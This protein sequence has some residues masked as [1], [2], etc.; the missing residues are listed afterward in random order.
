VAEPVAEVEGRIAGWGG[1]LSVAAVNGPRATVVSGEPGALD[2]LLAAC[3]VDG[4]RARRIPVDYASHS[5]QVDGLRERILTD[6]ASLTPRSGSVPF[7]STVTGAE[8][9]TAGLDGAYWFENL[10]G[11]VRFAPVVES[12]VAQGFGTFV[13]ASAHPVLTMAIEDATAIGSLRRGEGGMERFVASL[14]EAWV[15]GVPVAWDRVFAGGRHVDVPTYPFQHRRYWL[16]AGTGTVSAAR[17][18]LGEAEHPLLA[19]GVEL[20]DSDGFLLT[21]ALSPRS[22]P[23]LADHAVNGVVLLPGT[24]M[25][26]MAVHAGDQVGCGHVDELVLE[27]PLALAVSGDTYLQLVV[28]AADETG[29]R[30]LS[31]H[32]RTGA[33]GEWT[34]HATGVISPNVPAPSGELTTWPPEGAVA[35]DLTDF[36]AGAAEAGF[37]Y[38][39]AFRGLRAAWRRGGAADGEIFAEVE[40]PEAAEGRGSG[41]FALHP[42]LFDAG[43]QALRVGGVL[44]GEG[45]LPFS[46]R[47]VTLH[48]AGAATVLR[49]RLSGRGADEVAIDVADDRG[50]PVLTVDSLV[51][52]P[53]SAGEAPVVGHAAGIAR[54]FLFRVIWSPLPPTTPQPAQ[55]DPAAGGAPEPVL[56]RL[57]VDADAGERGDLPR[58]AHAAVADALERARGWLADDANEGRRLVLV[59]R[60]AV[61]VQ[62]GEDV[63]DL[64]GAAAWGLLRSAQAEHPGRFTLLDTD[65]DPASDG[66][67][68]AAVAGGEPQLALRSGTAYVPRLDRHTPPLAAPDSPEAPEGPEAPG[69]WRLRLGDGSAGGGTVQNVVLAACPEVTEPLRPGQ[70]RVSVR[71]AGVNFRDVVLALG[72]VTGRDGG[73]GRDELGGEGAGVVLDVA[74]DVADLRPGDRVMG[75]LPGSFG[76]LAVADHRMLV[77]IP[78][79][80][81]FVQ[82]ATVPIAFL[83][84]AYGLRDLGGLRDGETVLVHAAAGGVGMAAVQLARHW[85]AEV[86]G[87]ASPGKWRTLRAHGLDPDHIASSRALGFEDAFRAATG[88]RGVDIVLNSLA[89]T[90][91]DAGQRLLAPGGRFIEMGKT[92]IRG[93]ALRD[94]VTYRAFDLVEARPDRVRDLLHELLELA[95]AG[96]LTPLPATTWDVRRAPEALRYLQQARHVGKIVL[97]LPAPGATPGRPL[98]PAGTVLITGGTGTLGSEV[99]RHLV[100][101]HGV[102]RLLLVSRRGVDAPGAA[103]LVAELAE[104]G[105]TAT[106]AA[107]DAADREELARLLA[108]I[109]AEHPLTAVIHAAGV[110]DDG[111]VGTL[112]PERLARVLRPKADAA[113]HLH[114]LTRDLDLAAFVLFSS[115]AGLLGGLGQGNY[116]AANAFLDG[117]ALHRRS[118]GLPA[119]SLAW[120]L[121]AERSGMTGGLGPEA[122]ARMGQAGIEEL[123]TEEGLAL[124][125][126]GLTAAET[127]LAP[128]RLRTAALR[129]RAAVGETPPLLR[130]LVRAAARRRLPGTGGD[131]GAGG[132]ATASA[133]E[134]L[135][136]VRT[137]ASAVLGHDTTEAVDAERAFRELGFD[138]LTAVELR[139]RLNAATGLRLPSTAVFDHPT[140]GALAAHLRSR[141]AP[142]TAERAVSAEPLTPKPAVAGGGEDPVVVVGMACRYPGGVDSP[143]ALWRLVAEGVDAVGAFP[144]DRGWDVGSL[145][146]PDPERSGTSYVREGGFLYGAAE[147]DAGFFGIS[148]REA[149][150]MDPQQRLL[151]ETSWEVFERAGIDPASVRSSATGVFTGLLHGGYGNGSAAARELEGYL[152]NG[153]AG[154]V[155]SGRVAYTFGLEGPAV[156]VD[157]ACSSSLVALHLAVQ[158]LRSG[159]CAMALAGGATV[160]A[161]PGAFVEFSRQR[162]LAPDGRCKPFAEGADGTGWAE[163]VGMLLLERLSDARRNGHRVLA[164]VRGSAVN[165]D[166]ASNG[167]TAPS[168]LAQQRVIRAALV[169]AGLSANE[170][171]AVEAHG[172]GTALGDP[173]EAQALLATYGQGREGERPLWLGSLKSNIGHAQAAAGVGG[174][175]KMVQAMHH[176]VLPR[177]L[178]VDRPSSHVDWDAGAVRLLTE[179]VEW[180]DTGRPRRA[181][182]SSFGVSGTNAHAILELPFDTGRENGA[183]DD[184][185]APGTRAFPVPVLLSADSAEALSAQ[186]LRLRDHLAAHPDALPADVGRSLALGRAALAHRAALTVSDGTDRDALLTDLD[187]LASGARAPRV[188]RGTPVDGTLAFLF[189][190]QGSQRPGM[191]TELAAAHPAFA[192][193]FDAVCAEFDRH[194]D[195]PLRQVIEAEPELLDRTE[196]AQPA[197][198]GV[199]VALFRLLESWQ[200]R[201]DHLLGHSAGAL[202]AAH[203]ADVLSLPDACLL[204]AARGRLMQAQRADGAMLAVQAT[205][206]EAAPFLASHEGRLALAAVNGPASVVLAG[207]ADAVDEAT[208]HWAAVGRRTKRLRTSHAFHSPHMDGML[209]AFATVAERVT[210]RPARIPVVSEVT[211][212]VIDDDELAGPAYWV[213]HARQPVRFADGIAYLHERGAR[214]FLELG[215]DAVLS[216]MGEECLPD[217]RDTAFLPT[218][219]GG[220]EE[221]VA[222][223]AAFGRLHVRGHAAHRAAYPAPAGART[224]PLPTYA[225]QRRRYWLAPGAPGGA[226]AAA[227][228]HPLLPD[229]VTLADGDGLLL[230]GR[231]SAADQPWLGDHTILGTVLV[232]GTALVEMAWHAGAH[233]GCGR[234]EELT[235]E[236]PLVLPPGGARAQVQVRVGAADGAGRRP[237]TLHSRPAADAEAPWTRHADGVLAPAGDT[238]AGDAPAPEPDATAWPPPGASAIDTADFYERFAAHGFDLGPAFQGLRAAWRDGDDLL[239]EVSLPE[240]E[241]GAAARYGIHPALLDAALHA[242]GLDA[243]DES[244]G[245][246][247]FAWHDVTRHA[248]GAPDLRVRLRPTGDDGVSVTLTDTVG[249]PV[250]RIGRLVT[251]RVTED[252]LARRQD[253][254]HRVEWRALP[255]ATADVGN[256]TD[257]TDATDVGDAV[258]RWAGIDPAGAEGLAGLD[259]LALH[260]DP[261]HLAKDLA[262]GGPL[263]EAVLVPLDPDPGL[264]PPEAAHDIARRAGDLVRAWLAGEFAP[265]RLV[266]VTRGAVRLGDAPVRPAAA[267]AWGL[268]ASVQAEHPGRFVLLDAEAGQPLAPGPLALALASDEPRLALRAGTAHVPRLVRAGRATPEEPPAPWDPEGTVLV[269]GATGALG[270]ALAR[271]LAERGARRL[272]LVSRSGADAP[273]AAELSA[274]LAALGATAE[275]RSCDVADRDGLAALLDGVRDDHPLTAVVHLAGVLDDGLVESLTPERLE[276]VLR[277]KADA[278]WHLHE[279]TKGLDLAAFVLFSSASGVIG[280]AGQANYAAANAFLDALAHHRHA[281]GLPAQSLAWGAWEV[282]MAGELARAD[283]DRLARSGAVPL[284]TGEGMALFDAACRTPEP[285]L[286]PLRLDP[287]AL[288]AAGAVP[289]LLRDL[290]PTRARRGA[291]TAGTGTAAAEAA[292]LRRRLT[293]LG[294]AKTEEALLDLIRAKAALAL[295]HAGADAIEPGRG[296]TQAGFDSLATVELRNRLNEVTG[297][298]LASTALFDHPTPV[299]LA[300][301]MGE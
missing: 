219:R 272:L 31:L 221:P 114:E 233:A 152:G 298:R 265:A 218:L 211:G 101:A 166:G 23:W 80:W 154:S 263:P 239:A 104:S 3:E 69:A 97:T 262:D 148:P 238:P 6:L 230:S 279:L 150:A 112:T 223:A 5:A 186:A 185:R 258:R 16:D 173:I 14:A 21:G 291:A 145:Y 158:S 234:V 282:G 130:G 41:D 36:Y 85:G 1:R 278:A 162:G 87:T 267:A 206:D 199:Q 96:V 160:M 195:R 111:V 172:T 144:V 151:L 212:A 165:Q 183:A 245:R 105:A 102:R 83:T 63:A 57:G 10:R 43:L 34:R 251:R 11:T 24:A 125:D 176:G 17:L 248:P 281:E 143:E 210:F 178:H 79:G 164:V 280:G 301:H 290:V 52:R 99:A 222:L 127:L 2:E 156:T 136:L 189:T 113:W 51:A 120:G 220:H 247:P 37:Q 194:L 66:A 229:V 55:G 163:G 4:V 266:L 33:S 42:A 91:V 284:T 217:A 174:V 246:L 215:P 126:A 116:A 146:D 224:I 252:Q 288:Q 283:R 256:A 60:G 159:E 30:S 169:N 259:G 61:A 40:L 236:A 100:A 131:G 191:G 209:D 197:L 47:G 67:V 53:F 208:V 201:P 196:Y 71:A 44:A 119:V 249:L 75:L 188:A 81:S 155:A 9:D 235:L 269:T 274:D 214:T 88:G 93:G 153:S 237:L 227:D 241:H 139:N 181:A 190:G 270:R 7:Y 76:P 198:F 123:S 54:D 92:D 240:E 12:L 277:P 8:L 286:V 202:A 48:A 84:A 65:D 244:A 285:H 289:P 25:L 175:I 292:A 243:M 50:L 77:R 94:D 129:A 110:L 106:V 226:P 177:T 167:L 205:P 170:V 168:G 19:A 135:T 78:D 59:T 293:G 29:R 161:T 27:A 140:P 28:S 68:A 147:F 257:A 138:S 273:G 260:A 294:A 275:L 86:F 142:E 149:L 124:L 213:R 38:G 276:R 264:P 268:L 45:R 157:T 192:A 107:C 187:A 193:A 132:F 122:L 121:W 228:A 299:A 171:D 98:P 118:L 74:D 35:A 296:F 46:W 109:P 141:L 103:E 300:R 232:P 184:A 70:V 133:A 179:S 137:Q 64:A 26:E 32:A 253:A 287:A 128:I 18:G 115:A 15:Q 72:M 255:T 90:F 200:V 250:A 73:E 117:L 297:L 20:V 82:A 207:D 261:V 134:L 225:F 58:A 295:G 242:G 108:A 62:Q 49:V 56:M 271:H 22:H 203:V 180:P 89:G 182:V 39:P 204:V 95:G 216:A 254:L 231:L 13:E